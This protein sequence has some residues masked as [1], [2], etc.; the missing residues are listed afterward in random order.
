MK[1]SDMSHSCRL[2]FL[3]NSKRLNGHNNVTHT[4]FEKRL[5]MLSHLFPTTDDEALSAS[6]IE[7]YLY[8]FALPF[9]PAGAP[10]S[11]DGIA[12]VLNCASHFSAFPLAE[13]QARWLAKLWR[14]GDDSTL[15][16]R[17]AAQRWLA[18][19]RQQQ[20]SSFA[21]AGVSFE[22]IDELATDVGCRPPLVRWLLLGDRRRRRL[23]L[24]CLLGPAVAQHY[25]LVDDDHTS[26]LERH[27]VERCEKTRGGAWPLLLVECVCTAL[28]WA[29]VAVVVATPLLVFL[30]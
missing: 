28:V 10:C 30:Q 27:V 12:F 7:P 1:L 25:R 22:L 23:A 13:M 26:T 19:K 3:V 29:F 5:P 18:D 8:R 11:L 2:A 16:H 20:R 4:G 24:A 6:T 14:Q 21:H 15:T 17:L 9:L